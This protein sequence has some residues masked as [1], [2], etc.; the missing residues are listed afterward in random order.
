MIKKEKEQVL[1]RHLRKKGK[2]V[3]EIA[4][5]LGVSK[6]SVSFWVRDIKLTK[7]QLQFL[8]YKPFLQEAITKRVATRLRNEKEK[9]RL[10][11]ESH[12]KTIEKID[13]SLDQLLIAGVCLYWAEGG[14]ADSNRIF[15]FSNSDPGMVK[16]IMSFIRNVCKVPEDRIKGHIHIHQHLNKA[17]ALKYWSEISGIPVSQFH[18]TSSQQNKASTNTRDT[19][20]YGTF[21]V[22]IYSTNLYLKMLAWIEVIKEK[23][24]SK[25][26][27]I[28]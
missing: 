22:G 10:I 23:I 24:L 16:V 20:P 11:I 12:K 13:L 28:K 6:G 5:S 17:V 27:S 21:S 8:A 18:K 2:S 19:L 25:Y 7:P 1:A 3:R 15:R 4:A 14:K 9:R 26:C